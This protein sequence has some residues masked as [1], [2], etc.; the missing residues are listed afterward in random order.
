LAARRENSGFNGYSNP[1]TRGCSVNSSA[2]SAVAGHNDSHPAYRFRPRQVNCLNDFSY[3][4]GLCRF[5]RPC[6]GLR[7]VIWARET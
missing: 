7:F 3:T 4:W 2:L 5:Y 1:E 6:L